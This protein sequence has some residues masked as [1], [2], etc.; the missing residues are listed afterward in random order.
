MLIILAL[1]TTNVIFAYWP[2][3]Q[4]LLSPN[5]YLKDGVWNFVVSFAQDPVL[6]IAIEIDRHC[7]KMSTKIC[8]TKEIAK[9]F[10]HSIDKHFAQDTSLSRRVV[11]SLYCKQ[12]GSRSVWSKEPLWSGFIMFASMIESSLK[13]N[14]IY[15][16]DVKSR[17]HFQDKKYWWDKG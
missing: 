1:L 8:E 14:W 17:Q 3:L 15:A 2:L 13:W 6:V 7:L 16:A 10:V 4:F 11:A 9:Y 12:Y 5:A